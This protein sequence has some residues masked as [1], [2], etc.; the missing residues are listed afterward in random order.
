[1][2][3]KLGGGVKLGGAGASEY[4]SGVVGTLDQQTNNSSEYNVLRPLPTSNLT[5]GK[6]SRTGGNGPYN[7]ALA[8]GKKYKKYK[9]YTNKNKS[10]KQKN[11]L[12]KKGFFS[13]LMKYPISLF[14]TKKNK[15]RGNKKFNSTRHSKTKYNR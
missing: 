15:K 7:Y 4:V 13:K 11:N 8:G 10:Y 5:G 14:K 6:Q 3:T 12:K 9:K 2:S 1:M